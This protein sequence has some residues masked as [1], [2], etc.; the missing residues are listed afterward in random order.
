MILPLIRFA[1][2]EPFADP[3]KEMRRERELCVSSF[4]GDVSLNCDDQRTLPMNG[5][6]YSIGL[7][8][9]SSPLSG[10]PSTSSSSSLSSS[11]RDGRRQVV[12]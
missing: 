11:V 6:R 1:M 12:N 9:V 10:S 4:H 8:G 2:G 5:I 7:S 3:Q